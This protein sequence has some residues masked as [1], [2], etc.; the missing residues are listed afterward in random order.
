VGS[1]RLM[2]SISPSSGHVAPSPFPYNPLAILRLQM[3]PTKL[4]KRDRGSLSLSLSSDLRKQTIALMG[5]TENVPSQD[6]DKIQCPKSSVLN[7][8]QDDG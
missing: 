7:K 4:G 8:R 2:P 6:E 1:N 5:S 3:E